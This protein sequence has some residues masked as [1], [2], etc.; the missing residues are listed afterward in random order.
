MSP[1]YFIVPVTFV[2]VALG[3]ASFIWTVR[4]G[5]YKE[6]ENSARR[7]LTDEDC[8]MPRNIDDQTGESTE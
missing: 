1:L 3:F 2:L 7:I 6:M 8:P 4:N 5:Q